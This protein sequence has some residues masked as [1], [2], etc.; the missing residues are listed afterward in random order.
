MSALLPMARSSRG[1]QGGHAP[2]RATRKQ[3]E[4]ARRLYPHQPAHSPSPPSHRA[5]RKQEAPF[6]SKPA[7]CREATQSAAQ[8]RTEDTL[9]AALMCAAAWQP[10]L[11]RVKATLL[12]AAPVGAWPSDIEVIYSCPGDAT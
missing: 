4:G 8:W 2:H 5:F 9:S 3:T 11:S 1:S 12:L 10:V 6:E 7:H